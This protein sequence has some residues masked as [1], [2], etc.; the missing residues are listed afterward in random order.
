MIFRMSPEADVILVDFSKE[1]VRK[2]AVIDTN[3]WTAVVTQLTD[4]KRSSHRSCQLFRS[5]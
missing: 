2:E 1:I 5:F 4:V 3:T